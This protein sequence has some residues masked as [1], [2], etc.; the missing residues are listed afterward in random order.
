MMPVPT[1]LRECLIPL[2]DTIDE[3]PLIGRLLCSCGNTIFTLFY[4]GEVHLYKGNNIPCTKEMDGNFFFLIKGICSK[5]N[6]EHLLLDTHFHG[7]DGYVCHDS[8]KAALPRPNLVE[9]ECTSCGYTKHSAIIKIYT[10]GKEDYL[11]ATEGEFEESR[12]MDSFEWIEILIKC[13]QC[14]LRTDEWVS[15]ETA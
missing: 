15:C 11:E 13:S 3:E 2:D 7:W 9:W 12:W 5:C 8:R 6:R 10:Q 14:N 4:P 1:H